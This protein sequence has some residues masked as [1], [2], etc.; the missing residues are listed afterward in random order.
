[1]GLGRFGGGIGA[2]RYLARQ[3]ALVTVTDLKPE[4][5]LVESLAQLRD[6]P[7]HGL[8]LG[9]H[10]AEDFADADLVVAS[11][12][13]RPHHQLLQL[14][15]GRGV[16]VTTEIA[17]LIEGRPNP[18]VAVTGTAGKSTTASLM[19]SIWRAAGIRSHFG[20]N[21][22]GS[23]L[24]VADDIRPDDWLV[25]ELS[26]FQLTY[27]DDWSP[28][29]AVVT[30]FAPNHL[31]WH[32]T[33]EEYRRAKQ[34]IL[35]RQGPGDWAVLNADDLE[36]LRWPTAARVVAC[37]HVGCAPDR[38]IAQVG[39]R[40]IVVPRPSLARLPGPH[41]TLNLLQAITA[42][43]VVGIDDKTIA[44]GLAAFTPLPHRLEF[45]GEWQGR[46]FYNDSKATTPE[47]AI[48][49]LESFDAPLVLLA[50]GS[51]KGADLA[52]FAAAIGRRAKA[53]ALLGET[54]PA[55][56]RLLGN[57]SDGSQVSR[58]V[59]RDFDAAF[60]WAVAQSRPGDV[61][62]LSPGCASFGWFR[63]YADRG[64]RFRGLV[65]G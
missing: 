49:A 26:S 33:V 1:M 2:A 15:R 58:Q 36:V 34:A 61:V 46:K 28:R 9:G 8:H 40:H 16:P 6:V 55:L 60:A 48:R 18:A 56:D 10:R 39:D 5:E 17:L 41:N 21:I 47:A 32:G 13:V 19:A 43:A 20:G 52:P 51:S 59:C 57:D 38:L 27:L 3:G 54:G 24:D 62:L 29:I 12:A 65:R 7:L 22:G 63:D 37:S 14:A 53:V 31:D 35:R 30:N 42:A 44:A 50:G 23:L 11:P 25:L 64:E 45:V 4:A